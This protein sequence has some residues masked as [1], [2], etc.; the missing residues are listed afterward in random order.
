MRDIRI[1]TKKIEKPRINGSWMNKVFTVA[2]I[3][4]MIA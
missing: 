2:S 3:P 1:P 4:E